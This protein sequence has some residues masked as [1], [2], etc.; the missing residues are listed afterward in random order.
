MSYRNFSH[1]IFFLVFLLQVPVLSTAQNDTD[2]LDASAAQEEMV[3]NS[4]TVA[5]N[6]LS[7][8]GGENAEAEGTGSESR[9]EEIKELI[10]FNV[11]FLTLFILAITYFLNKFVVR[12]LDNISE[13]SA[14]YRLFTK[15]LVPIAR[16]TIWSFSLYIII[17]GIIDPPFETVLT[18]TASIGIA[19]GFASQD[20][21]KN[22]FGGFIIILDRPFQVGDKIQV[23]EYYGEVLQIGLR[24]CRIVTP[25]DSVVTIPNGEL[26]NKA[27]SNANS[28]ALDCQVVAEIYLPADIDVEL[29]KRI[30]YKAAISSRYAYLQKPV[31]V[32]AKN[33]IH[34]KN[35]VVKLRVKAY[36]LDIRYEFPFQ[37]DMT[38][39]ILSELNKRKLV[40][41]HLPQ[42]S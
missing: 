39:L 25:D 37:S 19:V 26:M 3:Q 24:S 13:K 15:R 42:A 14:R 21:L 32:I 11:I 33:E 35:Y 40:P 9:L 16:I 23:G 8:S 38:E 10:S 20:I 29:V 28:S 17:A 30:A 34:Q 5:Q 12:I 1:L 6:N 4:D 36:V 18:V 2:T 31:I 27:V 22:V 7:E 41:G